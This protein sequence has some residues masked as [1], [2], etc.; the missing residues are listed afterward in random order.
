M[1]KDMSVKEK[2][3]TIIEDGNYYY[4]FRALNMGDNSDLEKGI[5]TDENGNF[6]KIRTDRQRWE[7]NGKNP[8]SKYSENNEISLKE[9][10]GH[11]KEN[12]DEDTNCISLS[13]DANVSLKYGNIYEEKLNMNNKNNENSEYIVVKIPREEIGKSVFDAEEYIENTAKSNNP[14]EITEEIIEEIKFRARESKELIHYGEIEGNK[15]RKVPKELMEDFA[16]LQEQ[17]DNEE[18]ISEINKLYKTKSYDIKSLE[19]IFEGHKP[20]IESCDEIGKFLKEKESQTK[21]EL[22]KGEK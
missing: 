15:I 8:A 9:V 12:H 22:E 21:E 3:N 7:E 1:E 5:I 14:N 6:T 17:G 20:D 13:S 10:I 2:I 16:K 19:K 11:I 18:I 4:L